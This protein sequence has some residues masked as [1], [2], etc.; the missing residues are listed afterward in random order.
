[1][2]QDLMYALKYKAA[3]GSEKTKW[4]K[5]GVIT[6]KSVL[7]EVIPMGHTGPLW[8]NRFDQKPREER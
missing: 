4:I 6:E 5:C 1:M 8:L 2:T 3:D 7:L